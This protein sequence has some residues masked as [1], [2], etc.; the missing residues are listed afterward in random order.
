MVLHAW[1]RWTPI[2][3]GDNFFKII[4]SWTPNFLIYHHNILPGVLQILSQG[5]QK[6]YR[7]FP[8]PKRFFLQSYF[9]QD[10][11]LIF[12]IIVWIIHTYSFN[13]IWLI[14]LIFN[15]EKVTWLCCFQ[16]YYFFSDWNFFLNLFFRVSIFWCVEPYDMVIR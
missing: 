8:L 2:K 6:K 1:D 13:F 11:F 9:Y 14:G 16:F 12:Y 5:Q 3:K 7:S 15:H 4:L 10:I